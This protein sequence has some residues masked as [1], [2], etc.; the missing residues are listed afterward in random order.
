[1]I[2]N[3]KKE[4]FNDDQDIIKIAKDYIEG[5]YDGDKQRMENALHPDMIKRRIVDGELKELDS[6]KMIFGTEHGGGKHVSKT[7]YQIEIEILDRRDAIAS[8]ITT[9]EYID[10]LH[11]AKVNHKWTIINVLWDFNKRL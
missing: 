8:V 11:L 7:S 6:K 1:M 9:S 5:W 3:K 4:R 10:Y 2:K